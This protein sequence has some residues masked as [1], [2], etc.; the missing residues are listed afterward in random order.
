MTDFEIKKVEQVDLHA[1]EVK[2]ESLSRLKILKMNIG[3]HNRSLVVAGDM[4]II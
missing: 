1:L 3:F 2:I 4:K